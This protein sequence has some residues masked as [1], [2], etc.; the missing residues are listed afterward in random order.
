M[1]I[2]YKTTKLK[3]ILIR[4]QPK[5]SSS[6]SNVVYQFKCP[7]A[8]CNVSNFSYIGYTTNTV[9]TRMLQHYYK[10]AIRTHSQD[11]HDRRFS[12]QEIL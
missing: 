11:N 12:K 6:A 3:N 8:E 10:G 5:L 9:P 1:T 2:Y 7:V 4:N